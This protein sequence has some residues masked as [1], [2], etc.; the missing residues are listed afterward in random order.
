MQQANKA[1]E[2]EGP[3]PPKIK[4]LDF[5]R[6]RRIRRQ[7]VIRYM[8]RYTRCDIARRRQ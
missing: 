6:N 8:E 2:K 7:S 4:D 5:E 1:K 3:V